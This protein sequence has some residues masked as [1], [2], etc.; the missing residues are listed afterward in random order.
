MNY[1]DTLEFLLSRLPMFQRIGPAAYKN[2]LDNILSLDEIYDHPHKRFKTIHVAGTNG[3]GSVSHMLASILQSA[4]YRTG[5]YTS[6]HLK[7]FRE[8]IRINGKMILKSEVVRWVRD[9]RRRNIPEE[10]DPS[11]FEITVAMAFDLFARKSVDVAVIEVGLGGRLDS[12]N[13]ITPEVSVITNI[14]LDHTALLGDTLEKIAIEKA[15]I[16]KQGVPVVIGSFCNETSAVFENISALKNSPLFFAAREYIVKYALADLSGN[17]VIA[18]G[19]NGLPVLPGLTLDL[20]G[21]Y[22]HKN[23]PTVLKTVDILRE[24]GWLIGD[25]DIYRGLSQVVKTTGLQGRW[26]VIGNNPLVVA[27]TAHNADGISEVVRQIRQTPYKVMHIVFGMVSDKDPHGVLRLLPKEAI[28]YF[29]KADIPRAL[30]ETKLKSIANQ[31]GLNGSKYPTVKAAYEAAVNN[32]G[33]DDFIFI[34]GSTFVVAEV[35]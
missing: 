17:Q 7:D 6:P 26:Q 24:K 19:K 5:L 22:Q 2:S 25:D 35:L 28:Y 23:L 30:D 20:K 29:T 9:F 12:T 31:I 3:K 14:G 34:G 8:R 27:D 33:K 13:I 1:S 10:T 16:I 21:M 18:T 32:A 15:G 4:G 11:F